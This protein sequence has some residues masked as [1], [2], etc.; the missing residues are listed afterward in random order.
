MENKKNLLDIILKDSVDKIKGHH[1]F[2]EFKDRNILSK[3]EIKLK[4]KGGEERDFFATLGF[5]N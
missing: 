4:N 2:H 3:Y 1:D 5:R